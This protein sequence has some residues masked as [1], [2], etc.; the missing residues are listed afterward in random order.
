MKKVKEEA[1]ARTIE[2]R[3]KK[4]QGIPKTIKLISEGGIE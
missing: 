3:E 4:I 1:S 2:A